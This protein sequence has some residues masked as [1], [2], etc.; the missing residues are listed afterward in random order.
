MY[1]HDILDIVFNYVE[2]LEFG[3]G[4]FITLFQQTFIA[5]QSVHCDYS[6]GV[7]HFVKL[8]RSQ[9]IISVIKRNAVLTAEIAVVP[10]IEEEFAKI[11]AKATSGFSDDEREA[12]I[13]LLSR[14]RENLS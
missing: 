3:Y 7:E 8:A 10:L 5:R 1:L 4:V 9:L 11:E 2:T 6:R 12:L 14:L 13:S